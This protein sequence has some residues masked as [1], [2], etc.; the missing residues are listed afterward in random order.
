MEDIILKY[1]HNLQTSARLTENDHSLNDVLKCNTHLPSSSLRPAATT[2]S[3]SVPRRPYLSSS[4]MASK[5]AGT[6]SRHS[7]STQDLFVIF[8]CTFHCV[9][10]LCEELFMQDVHL[11][12]SITSA[13]L[14]N[15]FF[16]LIL[17]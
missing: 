2:A 15:K 9:E 12:L 6:V 4:S 7:W 3:I 16:F 17:S 10:Y 13:A 5:S 11:K 14:I 8:L 1:K